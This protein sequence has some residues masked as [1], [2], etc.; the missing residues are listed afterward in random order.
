MVS[1]PV[2]VEP[3]GALRE[4]LKPL[5]SKQHKAVL[6]RWLDVNMDL[7]LAMSR[8]SLLQVILLT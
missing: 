8:R 2:T 1:H 3:S 6:K 7:L 4:Q 5:H